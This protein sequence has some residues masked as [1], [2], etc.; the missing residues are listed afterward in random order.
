MPQV[1][2]VHW[3][4]KFDQVYEAKASCKAYFDYLLM[5]M[6]V[7]EVFTEYYSVR[8]LWTL[9]KTSVAMPP[10]SPSLNPPLK[11]SAPLKE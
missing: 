9:N 5:T 1:Y 7:R 3:L 10:L 8:K 11:L 4:H 2:K 6:S